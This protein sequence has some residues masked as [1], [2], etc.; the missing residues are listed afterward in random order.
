[1]SESTKFEAYK[2]KL[3]GVCDENNLTFRF[4]YNEYPITLTIQ[5]VTGLDEQLSMMESDEKEYNS[6]DATIVFAYKDGALTYKMAETFSISDALFSKIKNL[7][8]NMHS[9]WLQFFFREIIGKRLLTEKTM[10]SIDEDDDNSSS[11]T[12]P[13]DSEED[14]DSDDEDDLPDEM[15]PIESFD[16]EDMQATENPNGDET[17]G[18]EEQSG[19]TVSKD[20]L[21]VQEAIKIVREAGSA[22]AGLLQRR[23]KVGYSKAAKLI[24]YLEVLGVVGPFNGSSPRKILPY[25]VQTDVQ[26]DSPAEEGA[27]DAD[28]EA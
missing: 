26:A 9:L 7:Y 22:S 6:P 3:Q 21:D 24:D 10:P 14:D 19:D 16:A 8:K 1:M 18:G 13:A 15:E 28:D 5:P 20:D 27:A 4:R 25:S 12:S 11:Q 17:E 2:K 23:M